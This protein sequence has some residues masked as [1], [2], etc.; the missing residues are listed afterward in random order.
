VLQAVADGRVFVERSGDDPAQVIGLHGWGRGRSDLLPA[1]RGPALHGR[2]YA[3]L[4]LPGFGHSPEPAPGVGAREYAELCREVV[5][6][7]ADEPVVLVGHSFGGRVAVCLAAEHPDL[8]RG[9][10]LTGVPL[11]RQHAVSKPT[12]AYRVGR[13]LH[14]HRLLSDDRMEALRQKHGSTDYRAATPVMRTVLVKVVAES[15]DDELRR[16]QC[17]TA[18]V[19]GA[20]DT[21]VPVAVADAAVA[22]TPDAELTVL[23]DADHDL[24]LTHPDAIASACRALLAGATR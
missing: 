10:V 13:S 19:W 8:V 20:R 4:D 24:P 18:L 15:Y 16:L 17:P 1:L 2:A 9:L 12:L 5:T 11:I 23:D 14:R 21:V 7:L 3:S 22:I 6:E